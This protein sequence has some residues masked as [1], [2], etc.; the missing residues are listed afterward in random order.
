MALSEWFHVELPVASAQLRAAR[1]PAVRF[2]RDNLIID[3]WD[4]QAQRSMR[5]R[6]E[7][8]EQLLA[9]ALAVL[10]NAQNLEGYL[11]SCGEACT[12]KLSLCRYSDENHA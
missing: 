2:L 11:A 1:Q 9:P 12:L 8:L 3:D 6:E 4:G 7:I 5:A 10:A